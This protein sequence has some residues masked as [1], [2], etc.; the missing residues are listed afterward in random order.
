[1][2]TCPYCAMLNAGNPN[3]PACPHRAKATR[4]CRAYKPVKGTP[5]S[6]HR[7]RERASHNK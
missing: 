2:K 5:P 1:M 6:R 3:P 7:E 4:P